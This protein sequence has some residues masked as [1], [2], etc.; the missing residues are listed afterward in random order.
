MLSRSN[1]ICINYIRSLSFTTMSSIEKKRCPFMEKCYRKNPIHFGEMSHPHLE[2]LLIDQLDGVIKIPEVLHFQC[3][4][5]S[6]L[7]D[8]LKVLQMVLRKERDKNRDNMSVTSSSSSKIESLSTA[9]SSIKEDLKE[10]IERHKKATALR[11]QDKLKQMDAEAQALSKALV[12]EECDSSGSVKAKK[13]KS[14]SIRS[15]LFCYKEDE[16]DEYR[17]Q[18]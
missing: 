16:T 12:N 18:Q 14:G 3:N 8:Q 13:K 17:K 4:D 6:Q 11:R 9:P 10:K 7:L 2:E 15:W 5:H 1:V